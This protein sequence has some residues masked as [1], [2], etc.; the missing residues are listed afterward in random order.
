MI[1]QYIINKVLL[2]F[3]TIQ[4]PGETT[5]LHNR[6]FIF[7]KRLMLPISSCKNFYNTC[8][9]ATAVISAM[10]SAGCS[11]NTGPSTPNISNGETTVGNAELSEDG[12]VRL[13]GKWLFA[14]HI[15]L[16]PYLSDSDRAHLKEIEVPA[17]WDGQTVKGETLSSPS[18]GTYVLRIHLADIE[19]PVSLYF[20]E[21]WS[22]ATVW[23]NGKKT[24][25]CGTPAKKQSGEV[26]HLCEMV[27]PVPSDGIVDVVVWVSSHHY[28]FGGISNP[29]RI[30]HLSEINRYRFYSTGLDI[31]ILSALL[32]MALYHFV[33]YWFRAENRASLYF[34]IMNAVWFVKILFEGTSGRLATVLFPDMPFYW[35]LTILDISAPL[36]V[37]AFSY[38]LTAFFPQETS[39]YLG[40]ATLATSIVTVAVCLFLGPRLRQY[41]LMG[42]FTTACFM[43]LY[44][45]YVLVLA[46]KHKRDG[47]LLILL[48][49]GFFGMTAFHDL[50]VYT[51]IM[52]AIYFIPIGCLSLS[53]AKSFALTN[54]FSN[55][56]RE[57]E[58]LRKELASRNRELSRTDILR[59]E[60]VAETSH[61]L[62]MPIGGIIQIAD[63]LLDEA[64]GS[65]TRNQ[66]GELALIVSIGRK[67]D[68]LI[69]NLAVFAKLKQRTIP[70]QQT[71]INLRMLV[72]SAV[73]VLEHLRP[74]P[75]PSF[76]NEV[77]NQLF[78]R[79][80][81]TR[82]YQILINLLDYVA[83]FAPEGTIRVQ[84]AVNNDRAEI[85]IVGRGCNLAKEQL[86]QIHDYLAR[87]KLPNN[88]A[89]PFMELGL[90]IS[91]KVVE[92]HG[93]TLRFDTSDEQS[94]RFHFSLPI[95]GDD[96]ETG[97]F[98]FALN[99]S[100]QSRSG[101][102][103]P[104]DRPPSAAPI[105][106]PPEW[107][108]MSVN[109]D[110]TVQQGLKRLLESTGRYSVSA[111]TD[112]K[113]ALDHIIESGPPDV[114]LIDAV[115]PQM[116]GNEFCSRLRKHY[117]Q[118]E[119]PLILL[120]AKDL[121]LSLID[122]FSTG[123]NDYLAKPFSTAELL[124]R[125]EAQIHAKQSFKLMEDKL[126][127]E[128]S[129][130]TQKI[131]TARANL[132]MLRYQLNPHFLFNALTSIRGA[133]RVDPQIAHKMITA[134]AEFY[135]LSLTN[136]S[137]EMI[138]ALKE[139]EISRKYLEIET[140]RHGAY[141][142]TDIRLAPEVETCLLPSFLLQPLIENAVKHGK[143]S[144]PESLRLE[145]DVRA[146]AENIEI[147]I[148]NTGQWIPPEVAIDDDK[149]AGMSFG[150][151][152]TLQRLKAIY[153]N[154]H[155]FS[156]REIDGWVH[157]EITVP[158]ETV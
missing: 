57:S 121:T 59:D 157:V 138:T 1:T 51:N 8:L 132:F 20:Q 55:I 93:S 120:T 134:L 77:P 2:Y 142:Q 33:V 27:V 128:K 69:G 151:K 34:A 17:F 62:K 139:I 72:T 97:T 98:S 40:R 115:M 18:F 126:S 15:F 136:S 104:G 50:L 109:N 110:L 28:V 119:A 103:I 113:N 45:I 155:R 101:E 41:L 88:E 56:F 84:A 108:V 14:P 143:R 79:A 153:S 66:R 158:R 30:G 10:L 135:R 32:I 46:V 75:R 22:A 80:D 64:S 47:S 94:C 112:P 116:G 76:A 31:A 65:L 96:E 130:E 44:T 145:V 60:F 37:P 149:A 123:V 53:V 146:A 13:S 38:F 95:S 78:V 105:V 39:K 114:I 118:I 71:R 21:I 152:N 125:V 67:I 43:L 52:Q 3:S 68:N 49:W 48:A 86:S 85:A 100:A 129:L 36:M 131:R 11:S 107:T 42:Y 7:R 147:C 111:F 89:H 9:A 4:H 90:S 140:L 127:L 54:R 82:L 24:E 144:S 106:K 92:L 63:G 87:S 91:Q 16:P 73:G 12:T 156:H 150:M 25:A 102:T 81:E 154:A 23:I 29:P 83:H 61:Q 117:S 26:P 35:M 99:R 133:V 122:G 137:D 58:H 74:I 124:A 6:L 5:L 148:S 141:L 70:L 19:P